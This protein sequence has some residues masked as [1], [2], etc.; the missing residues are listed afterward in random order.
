MTSKD[1]DPR[2][3]SRS[4]PGIAALRIVAAGIAAPARSPAISA[5]SRP[6][7][8]MVHVTASD[9]EAQPLALGVSKSVVI[10]LPRDI[11]DVLVADPKIAN[12]VVRS[13]RRAYII[14]IAAGQT[15][16]FFFDADGKQIAGF[17]IAVTRDLN[18]MRAG[19]PQVLPDADITVEGIGDGVVLSGTASS[20]AEA[21]QA[22]DIAARLLGAGTPDRFGRAARSSTPSSFAA[23]IRS[24]SR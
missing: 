10:D 4:R 17:D 3:R 24:C 20:Q 16:V 1:I 21:Q 7:T 12:A 14:G 6:P 15:N 19:D 5:F 22:Y 8:Q 13:A 11:K 2:R 9:V 23:A 18:G